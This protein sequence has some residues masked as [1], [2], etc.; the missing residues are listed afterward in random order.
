M[1]NIF[2]DFQE[3]FKRLF[4][5]DFKNKAD[6]ILKA[7][8][9]FYE[10]TELFETISPSD[11]RKLEEEIEFYDILTEND[12][13]E[14]NDLLY[15]PKRT[16]KQKQ[17]MWALLDN[18]AREV[19]K[20]PSEEQFAIRTTIRRFLKVYCFLIQATCYEDVDLHKRYNYLS[21]LVK[22][23]DIKGGN[24]FDIADK[25]TVSDFE[26]KKIAEITKPEIKSKPELKI[27]TPKPA[28]P[29]AEQLKMLSVI[30]EELNTVYGSRGD[31]DVRTKA[32]LQIRELLLKDPRLKASA[33]NNPFSDFKFTYKD[34]V[35]DA[36]V[37]GYDDNVDFY[38]LLLGNEELRDKIT[39]IFAE[40]IYRVL[41]ESN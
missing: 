24:D 34:S 31:P 35:S 39:N 16:S 14:F 27:N 23:L 13:A 4:T 40:E 30:I 26:Q 36:L 38:T 28:T 22:E 32:A 2:S 21:Y 12:I 25:I 9:P 20:K 8:A 18:S 15:L 6:D 41:R 5:F 19:Y 11:I 37:K 29:E 3:V 10:E 17:R 7:F 1:Q 33:K